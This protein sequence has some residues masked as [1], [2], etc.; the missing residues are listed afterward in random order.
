MIRVNVDS[1]HRIRPARLDSVYNGA[2]D[3]GSGSIG[4]LE[5]AEKFIND[6]GTKRPSA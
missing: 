5:I 3:D 4:L 2:D 6:L 1:L